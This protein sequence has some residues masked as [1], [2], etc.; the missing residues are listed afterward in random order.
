MH[1]EQELAVIEYLK[2]V[3]KGL[4]NC[5][6][7]IARK[8]IELAQKP[9]SGYVTKQRMTNNGNYETIRVMPASA[10]TI[11][12]II[13]QV[14]SGKQYEGFYRYECYDVS[15]KHM[16]TLYSINPNLFN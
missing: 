5:T 7:H 2:N 8:V 13:S 14:T 12:T 3:T 15:G 4:F 6:P 16:A 1:A 10:D 11:S 9:P